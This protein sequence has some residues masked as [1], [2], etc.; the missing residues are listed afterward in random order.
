VL[1]NL[2]L[3][4]LR[5]SIRL[6]LVDDSS[7]IRTDYCVNGELRTVIYG[8]LVPPPKLIKEF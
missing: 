8:P 4:G 3:E 7:S 2:A 6:A 5:G 1:A